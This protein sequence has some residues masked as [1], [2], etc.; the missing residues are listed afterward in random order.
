M[1]FLLITLIYKR[2]KGKSVDLYSTLYCIKD[3]Y[4]L[5]YKYNQR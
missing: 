4:K 1:T 3:I 5:L 2:N